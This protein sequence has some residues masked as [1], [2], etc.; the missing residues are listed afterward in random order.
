MHAG[1]KVWLALR[2]ELGLVHPGGRP[3][4]IGR[5]VKMVDQAKVSLGE[6]RAELVELAETLP[7]GSAAAKLSRIALRGLDQLEEIIDQRLDMDDLK[8][9]RLVG[10]MAL[11]V[12]KLLVKA[13][14]EERRVDMIGQLLAE[15]GRSRAEDGK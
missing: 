13:A 10:D 2:H 12:N 5:T 15:L 1:R 8:Q 6:Y 9:Q 7:A 3:R 4:S 14:H 11:G